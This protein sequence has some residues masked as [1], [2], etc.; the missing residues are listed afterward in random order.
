MD[1]A[2]RRRDQIR[3]IAQA[4]R[5]SQQI[6]SMCLS[7]GL[8]TGGGYWLDLRYGFSPV[9]TICGAAL[10]MVTAGLSLRRMLE[11]MDRESRRQASQES[12]KPDTVD[13]SE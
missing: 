4:Y 9:F 10:G 11:K 3:K 13:Q 7:V 2:S 5:D 12:R 1:P 6:M 8:C